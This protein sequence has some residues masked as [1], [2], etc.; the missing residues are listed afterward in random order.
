MTRRGTHKILFPRSGLEVPHDEVRHFLERQSIQAL[1]GHERDI[2][3]RPS[4]ETEAIVDLGEDAWIQDV[5]RHG[6]ACG[7]GDIDHRRRHGQ[8]D[9]SEEL[10]TA[11]I[12]AVTRAQGEIDRMRWER[13]VG[14]H[15]RAARVGREV[16]D[17][18]DEI[19]PKV[20]QPLRA[21]AGQ[22]AL[23]EQTPHC[24][25]RDRIDDLEVHHPLLA[26]SPRGAAKRSLRLEGATN[27][28]R[29]VRRA[30]SRRHP[31]AGV[32][33]PDRDD[34]VRATLDGI[35]DVATGMSASQ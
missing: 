9:L 28:D 27:H 18:L 6:L 20:A 21:V 29:R 4:H 15:A 31:E 14:A 2:I 35:D 8:L 33:R 11:E 25:T 23:D 22:G 1:P 7:C 5:D 16:L 26:S 34:S 13:V 19:A 17:A 3:P 24:V 10:A 12:R 32:A 30:W